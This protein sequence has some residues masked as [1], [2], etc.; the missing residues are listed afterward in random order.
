MAIRPRLPQEGRRQA[1]WLIVRMRTK[2]SNRLARDSH[3]ISPLTRQARCAPIIYSTVVEL[4]GLPL[5][6]SREGKPLRRSAG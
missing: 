6:S 3:S 4:Y 5:V 2:H 1:F